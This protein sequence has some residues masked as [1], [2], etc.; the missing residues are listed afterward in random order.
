MRLQQ[1]RKRPLTMLQALHAFWSR[2]R[3]DFFLDSV[4]DKAL[5][6]D[7]DM[8]QD[9]VGLSTDFVAVREVPQ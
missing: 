6:V 3:S 1:G 9:S 2:K 4:H 7:H 5:V 8:T